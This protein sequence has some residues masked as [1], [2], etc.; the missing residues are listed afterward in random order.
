MSRVLLC[1]AFGQDNPGD[2]ALLDA[3]VHSLAPHDV[4]VATPVPPVGDMCTVSPRPLAIADALRSS[5]AV[6]IAGGTVF[7]SLHPSVPRHHL[8]LL[9]RARALLA[10]AHARGIPFA[11]V[12]VGAG[13]L[14]SPIAKRLAGSVVANADLVVLRD[15]ESAA[16][17]RAAGT[18]GPFRIGA[19]PAWTIPD[20]VDRTPVSPGPTSPVVV[21]LSHLAGDDLTRLAAQVSPIVTTLAASGVDVHLQPWQAHEGPDHDLARMIAGAAPPSRHVRIVDRPAS[22]VDAARRYGD[23]RALVG[24]RHHGLVAAGAAGRPF[25][26]LSHEPKL[27]GLARRLGQQWVPPHAPTAVLQASA[28]TLL[29]QPAPS[30]DSINHEVATAGQAMDLLR[31]VV[32]GGV[33]DHVL[34]R[35]RLALTTDGAP[36]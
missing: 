12:G 29:D 4:M 20:L 26:A 27:A 2:D 9:A 33:D 1:G 31:V 24:L 21:A 16:V 17:L 5:D 10:G 3:F 23:A 22:I 8:G 15:E 28:R 7:K 30:A 36:W 32:A 19:D 14:R 25:L 13:S 35:D 11:L 6:V 34:D 18:P